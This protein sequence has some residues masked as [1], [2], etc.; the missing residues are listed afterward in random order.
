MQIK[1]NDLVK[2]AMAEPKAPADL[3]ERTVARAKAMEAQL[4]QKENVKA[5]E[6]DGP[7]LQ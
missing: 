4:P 7:A 2:A 1:F 6:N 3:V 5:A